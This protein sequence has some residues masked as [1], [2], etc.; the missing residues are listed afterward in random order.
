MILHGQPFGQGTGL[1]LMDDVRCLGNES[2]FLQCQ[3]S[4][5]GNHNCYHSKDVSVNCTSHKSIGFTWY[6]F[7]PLT[8]LI[9]IN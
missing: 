6:N 8:I 1:I 3:H 4:G 2:S 9:G 5:W 7:L